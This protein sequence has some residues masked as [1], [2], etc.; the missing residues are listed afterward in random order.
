ADSF[1][2]DNTDLRSFIR[3]LVQSNAY[4]LSSEYEGEWKYEYL[5]MYARH[6]PRRLDAEEIHDAIL[7][8][9]GV[10]QKYTW[11]VVNNQTVLQGTA[12]QQSSPVES[13]MKLPDINEPRN[14]G[15]VNT[16]LQTFTRGN[17]DTAVRSQAGSIL[18]QLS[19]MNDAFVLNRTKITASPA[20]QSI[21][22][23]PEN[24]ALLD[25]MFLKF[26][27]RKPSDHERDKAVNYLAKAPVRNAAIE[28]LA[29]A[30]INK[31]DFLFSY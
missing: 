13:A 6:Y 31:L 11:P 22:K 12:L 15:A 2:K 28:D 23:I 27:A 16:F 18:Q 8:T 10:P 26:L 3:T 7:Q 5:T 25:E 14:N 24:N 17:R 19:I 1:M 30:C 20:L 29:W 4:Q 9:T 21:A